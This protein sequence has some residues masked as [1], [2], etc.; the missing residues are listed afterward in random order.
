MHQKVII[1]ADGRPLSFLEQQFPE[2]DFERF[3]S[4]TPSY[5]KGNLQTIKLL[6]QLPS[7]I[8]HYHYDQQKTAFLVQKTG[9]NAVISENRFGAFSKKVPSVYITHQLSIPFSKS[10]AFLSP[11]A[12]R[13]HNL[14]IS[15][16]SSCWIPDL[17]EP[18][19]LAGK[20]SKPCRFHK[21]YHYI[22]I[23]SR[24][25]P[26]LESDAT[27]KKHLLV[28]L[29][30][31]EPQRSI[32]E[33]KVIQQLESLP[34]EAFILR[35]LPDQNEIPKSAAHIRILNHANDSL[36]AE[37]VTSAQYIVARAGY[38]TIMDLVAMGRS[39]TLIPTPGQAEQ[40]YL[41]AY[42]AQKGLFQKASQK[43][44]DLGALLLQEQ[45]PMGQIETGKELL[46][47]KIGQWLTEI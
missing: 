44:F 13:L 15:N 1:A 10:L 5:S 27:T 46:E 42:M 36:L 32:L 29:S 38:S 25:K 24:F 4:F 21:S 20:L 12:S 39:A 40:E 37:L 11:F 17:P 33:K 28:L 3:E 18:L 22:G 34:V 23:L 16:Y 7:F 31:P 35:G 47:E 19:S 30:G 9:A 2:L 6:S 41:A 43:A 8:R 26:V 14:I 45:Q